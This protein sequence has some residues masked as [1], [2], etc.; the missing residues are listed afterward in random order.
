MKIRLSKA[1]VLYFAGLCNNKT[2]PKYLQEEIDII[3]GRAVGLAK[4]D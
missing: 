4:P 2:E 1:Q 3:G